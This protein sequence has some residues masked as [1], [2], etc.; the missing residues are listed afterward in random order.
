MNFLKSVEEEI[1]ESLKENSFEFLRLGLELVEKFDCQYL[2]SFQTA[3]ANL[4]IAIELMLKA[5]IA[6]KSFAFLFKGLPDELS[7]PLS[8]PENFS[9]NSMIL[10]MKLRNQKTIEFDEAKG[11]FFLLHP[12]NRQE[13]GGYLSYARE[14]RNNSVHFYLPRF[15]KYELDRFVYISLKLF[16]F[17]VVGGLFKYKANYLDTKFLQTYNEDRVNRIMTAVK[18]AKER[19][20]EMGFQAKTSHLEDDDMHYVITCPVCSS[21]SLLNG[22]YDTKFTTKDDF[23]NVTPY[24]EFYADS[25][26]CNT[27]GLKAFDPDEIKLIGIESEYYPDLE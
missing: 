21:D 4:G 17:L 14:A 25:F 5:S 24:R 9:D 3:M 15:Q 16:Q 7:M 18:Q 11:R 27:C 20:K 13:F 1:T 8:Y 19:C 23:G 26:E 6:N 10:A 12:Q 22:Y 2:G